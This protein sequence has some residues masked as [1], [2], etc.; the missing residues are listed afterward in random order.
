MHGTWDA[1]SKFVGPYIASHTN[2]TEI[3]QGL[4]LLWRAGVT[5]SKVVLGQGFYGRSFTLSDASCNTPNGVCQFSGPANAGPCSNAPGILDLQEIT[6]IISQNGLTPVHDQ[7]AGVKWITWD[8]NQWISYDDADT[9]QQKRDFASSRCLGGMMVWAIDQIDQNGQ[10]PIGA[11]P[12][13]GVSQSQQQDASQATKDQS[14]ASQC[15]ATKCGEKCKKG[16]KDVAQFNG[17]PGDLSTAD[18][19]GKKEYRT[20]CCNDGTFL[21]QCQY[22]G[23][24]GVGLSCIKGCAEGET[25]LFTD[26]NSHDAK[27]GDTNCNGGLQSFCCADF[28][29]A[30]SK[31]QIEKDGKDALESAAENA[32]ENA[33]LDIA[34]KAFCRIAV[35]ALLAPLELIEDAIPIIG[36]SGKVFM[37]TIS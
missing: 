18:R 36:K 6:D 23:Y 35:P 14:V 33:A 10:A 16:T 4:D 1:A 30:P 15:Y 2:I 31:A 11:G 26:T 24:R 8:N 12:G 37:Q 3:D 19:C 5:S 21:G 22:R 32:A 29:P 13:A 7:K 28:R 9:F 20:W 25:E 27:H 17:Q 34:A